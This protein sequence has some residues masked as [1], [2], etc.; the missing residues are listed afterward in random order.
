M[1]KSNVSFA[2][3][4]MISGIVAFPVA[5]F[6]NTILGIALLSLPILLIFQAS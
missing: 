4:A 6:V 2:I 1:K 5:A 3:I